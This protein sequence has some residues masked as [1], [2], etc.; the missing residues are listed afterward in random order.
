M[1]AIGLLTIGQ[2]PRPDQLADDVAQ[3]LG[4][5]VQVIERGALDG[6]DAGQIE[7]MAPGD[8]D[9][10]LITMLQDGSSAVIAKQH[11]LQRLQAQIDVLESGHQVAATLLMCTGAFPKFRHARPL[12]APQEALYGTVAGLAGSG[13]IGAIVPLPSQVENARIKWHAFGIDDALISPSNPYAS[14]A[15]DSAARAAK[16]LRGDGATILFLDCFGFTLATKAA[17]QQ[18]FQGPVVLARSMAAR[19]IA[20][21]L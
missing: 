5:D 10:H 7:N 8:D 11:I 15:V 21:L 2:A 16:Q 17:V 20:E 14:D 13:Q 6:L 1:T 18:A 19:L 4:D 12:V 3:V 9:Y